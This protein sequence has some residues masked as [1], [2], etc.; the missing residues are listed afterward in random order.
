MEAMH[1]GLSANGNETSNMSMAQALSL[2]MYRYPIVDVTTVEV[3]E[4]EDAKN[5]FIQWQADAM[6]QTAVDGAQAYRE[7]SSGE[8]HRHHNHRIRHGGGNR[9]KINLT[10]VQ[11]TVAKLVRVSQLQQQKQQQAAA[12]HASGAAA[13]A[14]VDSENTDVDT[15]D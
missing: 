9:H 14:V 12:S 13:D 4:L 10:D 8:Q 7:T 3:L 5:M 11:S 1:F 2:N 15:M 6:Q